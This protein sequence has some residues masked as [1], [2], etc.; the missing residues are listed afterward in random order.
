MHR[1]RYLPDLSLF[2]KKKKFPSFKRLVNIRYKDFCQ[3]GLNLNKPNYFIRTALCAEV[4]EGKLY[5][6]LPPLDA[7]E[8]FLDLIASI[9]A[10]AKELNI[11][12]IMEGYDPPHDNRLQSMKITP[13]PGVIEVNVHPMKSWGELVQNTETLYACLLY[14]SPSPRDATLSRMP[15]SA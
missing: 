7:A 10:T 5:L 6:F 14:T 9:E 13:D 12:V 15:S 3:N 4:R 11:P 1:N 2:S 8:A